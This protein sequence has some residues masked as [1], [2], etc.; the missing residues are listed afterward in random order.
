MF[1]KNILEC[2]LFNYSVPFFGNNKKIYANISSSLMNF[3]IYYAL[4][5][6]ID[7][8]KNIKNM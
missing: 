7:F 6:L 2:T 5:R 4:C 3:Y 1:M 8:N